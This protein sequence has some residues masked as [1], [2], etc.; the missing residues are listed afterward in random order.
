MPLTINYSKQASKFLT[1]LKGNKQGRLL[2]Q[3]IIALSHHPH[4]QDS[5]TL[6]GYAG[7]YRVDQGEFR[8]LYESE[9]ERLRVLIVGRRNDDEVYKV[10]KR[11]HG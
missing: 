4:P 3:K 5:A 6:K 2:V 7:V 9:G 10:L 8:I 1:S 11:L